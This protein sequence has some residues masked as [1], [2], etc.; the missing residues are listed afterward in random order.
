VSALAP[1]AVG[2]ADAAVATRI[3]L[4]ADNGVTEPDG[5]IDHWDEP[6]ASLTVQHLREKIAAGLADGAEPWSLVVHPGDVSYATGLLLKWATFTARWAGVSDIVPYM[7]G[8]GNH[9]RDFPGSGTDASY[10]GSADSGGECGK[11]TGAIFPRS[12]DWRAL[13]HGHVFVVMLNSEMAVEVGSPQLTWLDAT[14]A[15]VDR[16]V[17]PWVIVAYHRP[18]YYVDATSAGGAGG[19]RDAHFAALEAVLVA[20]RVDA[21][22]VGHVHNALVT[23]PVADGVCT[24]GAPVH[25]CVGNAGQGLTSVQATVPAWVRF[26][27]SAY[28]WATL[29]ADAARMSI[30]LF[31]D[32]AATGDAPWYV[33]NFTR[34]S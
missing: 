1:P 18:S 28:G 23:C 20:R 15:A 31:A 27:K 32:A 10:E 29:E 3:L 33:A 24:P 30:A 4:L 7:V 8:Q 34:A 25:V 22:I 16:A 9:E 14:L 13:A 21:A 11:V 2:G 17:T 12:G 26:Q 6:S 5:T 19:A